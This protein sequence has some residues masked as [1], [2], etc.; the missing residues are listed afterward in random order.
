MSGHPLNPEAGATPVPD[1]PREVAAALRAGELS[2]ALTPYYGFRYGE[3]GR[4]FTQS[5]SAFLVTLADHT[6]PVVDRQIRWMAGL[7]SNRGMP[8]LLLEQHLRVL[9][10]TLCREVPRRAAS[11]GRLLEA[12]GLLRELRRTHLPDAACGALARSFVREAGLPPTWLAF[13]TGRLIAAAVADERAGF[14]S[15]VT[16]LAS[17]LADPEQFPPRFISAVNS[18]IAEAQAAARPG[19]DTT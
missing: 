14:R 19:A 18:T 6:R 17:W 3:R 9:H 13:G 10:R 2:L 8:S 4:R 5:D 7:L 12:A 16:S 11:Y 1:D 15:A